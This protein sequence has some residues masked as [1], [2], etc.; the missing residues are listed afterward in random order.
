M[1]NIYGTF[2]LLGYKV[3]GFTDQ[4]N[5]ILFGFSGLTAAL[6]QGVFMRYLSNYKEKN[7]ILTG[8]LFMMFGLVLM[9]Y[10]IN[11]TG[12]AVIISIF[13]IGTGIHQPIILSM[14]S[15]LSPDNEQGAILGLNQS[16]SAFARVLGP[17]WGGFAYDYLGYQFPFITGAFFTLITF[18]LAYFLLN[19]ERKTLNV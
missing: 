1:A 2:A 5:G 18:L 9:P 14:V 3:Y 10:G 17:L 19:A 12:V 7:V 4:Q 16:F 8:S 11:F 15:K 13:S 6:V